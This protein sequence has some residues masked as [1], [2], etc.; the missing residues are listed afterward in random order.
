LKILLTGADGFTGVHFASAAGAAGHTVAASSTDLRDK[1]ALLAQVSG[2]R[3]DAVVHLA[4]IAHVEHEN[5]REIYDVN[6]F[7]TLNLLDAIEAAG[8]TPRVLLASSAN[9]YGNSLHS[10]LAETEMPAPVNHYAMSKLSM[11]FMARPYAT[12]LPL[13]FTRP[14]NYVGPGQS[15]SFIVPK[16]V[17]HFARKAAFVNLGNL[18]VEREFN[19]VRFVSAA[20]L[21]LLANAEPGAT[22]NICTGTTYR[23]TD[24]LALLEDITGHRL[25]VRVDPA[26]VR[27]NEIQRLCGDPSKLRLAVGDLPALS[28]RATLE[29]M[30]KAAAADTTV[31]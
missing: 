22:Y 10:P 23:L 20:Y 1:A 24:L 19:D 30:I 29:W 3:P 26:F 15:E 8:L 11:E 14:F 16:L 21:G 13:F 6:L 2:V 9:V 18:D 31:R 4:G 25:D 27:A 7:G 17:A 28:L 12:R 5:P